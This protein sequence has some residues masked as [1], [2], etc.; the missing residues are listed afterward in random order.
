M[1]LGRGTYI[2]TQTPRLG[3][4]AQQCQYPFRPAGWRAGCVGCAPMAAPA[5]THNKTPVIREYSR[6]RHEQLR[7]R[8][9]RGRNLDVRFGV[10]HFIEK[11]TLNIIGIAG[12]DI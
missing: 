10:A 7:W 1:G 8:R 2:V 6:G 5:D 9:P 12:I 4:P 11:K 3:G